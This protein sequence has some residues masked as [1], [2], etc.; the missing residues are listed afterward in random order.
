[1]AVILTVF[2]EIDGTMEFSYIYWSPRFK[3][4]VLYIYIQWIFDMEFPS[5]N[6]L[7]DSL[8]GQVR[9]GRQLVP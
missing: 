6:I 2:S 4:K 1:M 8:I 5:L 3:E 9:S 7:K